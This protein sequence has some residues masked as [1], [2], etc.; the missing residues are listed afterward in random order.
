MQVITQKGV[1]LDATPLLSGTTSVVDMTARS[2]G[3]WIYQCDVQ[4]RLLSQYPIAIYVA[5][6]T[7]AVEIYTLTLM[8]RRKCT[9]AAALI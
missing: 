5:T 1:T 4:V 3:T 9:C 8:N 6:D 2:P 7:Y